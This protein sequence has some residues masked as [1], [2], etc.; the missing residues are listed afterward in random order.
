MQC[1]MTWVSTRQHWIASSCG[2]AMTQFQA[3]SALSKAPTTLVIARRLGL[4]QRQALLDCFTLRVRND[5]TSNWI[6]IVQSTNNARG[7]D[8]ARFKSA[9]GISALLHPAI[10]DD[11]I[12][13]RISLQQNTNN[14][15][16]CER[17]QG[18]RQSSNINRSR[19][20]TSINDNVSP[21]PRHASGDAG[22]PELRSNT[23][24]T[25]VLLETQY[26][27]RTNNARHCEA[28]QPPWQSRLPDKPAMQALS[29]LPHTR[30]RQSFMQT[31]SIPDQEQQCPLTVSP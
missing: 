5:E 14:A 17:A 15:R 26:H 16:H 9:P 31:F 12:S 7:S 27:H 2:L 20:G 1:G 10:R 23:R 29:R 22:A 24:T 4:S 30:G 11:A 21:H 8:A 13:S 3:R 6:S 19:S 25:L 28:A 18:A